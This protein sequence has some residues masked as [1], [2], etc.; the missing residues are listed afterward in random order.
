[1]TISRK[2]GE[3]FLF[4][5]QLMFCD[6]EKDEMKFNLKAENAWKWM[7]NGD[8]VAIYFLKRQ[9]ISSS[10]KSSSYFKSSSLLPFSHAF[11]QSSS[12]E[13]MIAIIRLETLKRKTKTIDYCF[14]IIEEKKINEIINYLPNSDKNISEDEEKILKAGLITL[15]NISLILFNGDINIVKHKKCML[16][17][18]DADGYNKLL[19][20][21]NNYVEMENKEAVGIILLRFHFNV[22][23]KN[24]YYNIIP[25]ILKIIYASINKEKDVNN[26]SKERKKTV[27]TFIYREKFF[28]DEE[29]YF[30][31]FIS[32]IFGLL[33]GS[34]HANNKEL[35][36]DE[37]LILDLISLINDEEEYSE[38]C[39]IL[40]NF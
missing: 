13:N 4:L 26:Y 40:L 34:L 29:N 33:S 35:F 37:N 36:F 3:I 6:R 19:N 12:I 22:E 11:S 5:F 31:K 10:S 16:E 18:E 38:Y 14:K 30:N 7:K 24:Q 20:L 1:M 39:C 17:M 25:I 15:M 27:N 2:Y 32:G 23:I 9:I 21:M 28:N 8:D